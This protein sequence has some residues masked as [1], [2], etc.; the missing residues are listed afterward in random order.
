MLFLK[1]KPTP[2][3][4]PQK[5]KYWG[6]LYY[7]HKDL[8]ATAPDNVREQLAALHL[9]DDRY[10]TDYAYDSEDEAAE[11]GRFCESVMRNICRS[12]GMPESHAKYHGPKQEP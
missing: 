9:G 8:L 12:A 7:I 11:S 1:S 4:A 6:N 10:L 2:D 5:Q 3:T